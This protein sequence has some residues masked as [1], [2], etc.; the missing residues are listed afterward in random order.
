MDKVQ[1]NLAIQSHLNLALE[2]AS[3]AKVCLDTLQKYQGDMYLG[4]LEELKDAIN[5]VKNSINNFEVG[6][7]LNARK[8][9]ED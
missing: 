1:K 8:L 7:R 4:E 3:T 5:D 2:S 9:L 6:L